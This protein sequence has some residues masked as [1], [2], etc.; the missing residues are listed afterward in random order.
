MHATPNR[1]CPAIGQIRPNRGPIPA[2]RSPTAEANMSL[3]KISGLR[4]GLHLT[5]AFTNRGRYER[6]AIRLKSGGMN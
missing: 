5:R 6:W 1:L 4:A 2:Q 3:L